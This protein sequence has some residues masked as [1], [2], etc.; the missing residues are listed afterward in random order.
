MMLA[1]GVGKTR[2]NTSGDAKQPK[3]W[4]IALLSAGEVDLNTHMAS[5]GSAAMAGQ[6]IRLL[7]VPAVP[8]DMSGLIENT[9]EFNTPSAMVKHLITAT[10]R[11]Y[12]APLPEYIRLLMRNQE[13]IIDD[14]NDDLEVKKAEVIPSHADGQ[15][16]RVF[17]FFFTVGF[18]GELA[19][20]YGLT[21][22]NRG[23]SLAVAIAIFNDWVAAKG[24]FGNQ[25]EK[26]LLYKLRCFF[27]KYQYSR[28]L[29]INAYDETDEKTLNETIGYRKNMSDGTI[30]F[31]AYPERFKDALKREVIA[32]IDDVLKLTAGLGILER[33]DNKHF[34]KA[35]RIKNK[36]IRMLVFN[37]KV[38]ADEEQ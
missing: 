15:D 14:F 18:A 10:Q 4:R 20:Q 16:N 36:F 33:T 17:D 34:T 21:G 29:P 9:H 37:G 2:A 11:C 7:P 35:V 13:K 25:E 1:N 24:G 12:G 3:T 22:W 19:T 23:E 38:L 5:I 26:M 8:K 28:F 32:D 27:Q 30:F 31:Y 6:N